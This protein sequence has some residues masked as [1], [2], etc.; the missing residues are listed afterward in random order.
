MK[1]PAPW[2]RRMPAGFDRDAWTRKNSDLTIQQCRLRGVC[3]G[4]GG[5]AGL[6]WSFGAEYG[7]T[8]CPECTRRADR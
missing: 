6:W 4:C 7:Y 8:P 2:S 1:H 3:V 5:T